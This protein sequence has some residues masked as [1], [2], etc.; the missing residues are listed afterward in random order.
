MIVAVDLNPRKL[1]W[2]ATFGATHTV[3]ASAMDPVAA[4]R[5]LTDG[6]GADYAFEAVGH[7]ESICNTLAAVRKGGRVVILGMAPLGTQLSIPF[8]VLL[9]EKQITQSSYGNARPRVDFPR[10]VQLYLQGKLLLDELISTRLPLADINN[11]FSRLQ[12]GL[13]RATSRVP[14]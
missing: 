7:P 10:L 12:P 5:D 4:V 9:G 6:R 3:D 2:A 13:R 1:E 8:D 14:W 11:G